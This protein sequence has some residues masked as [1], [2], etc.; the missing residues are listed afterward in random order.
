MPKQSAGILLYRQ[1]VKG[2]EM[3][4]VH[5]G[6]PFWAKKD[7]GVWSIPK[8]EFGQQEQPETAARRE[9]REEVGQNPPGGELIG[10]GSSKSK[11]GKTIYIWATLGN[12]D[13]KAIKSN[14]FTMQWPLHSGIEQAFPEVDRAGWFGFEKALQKIGEPQAI[15]IER[16]AEHL[17]IS[18]AK[19]EQ[20]TLF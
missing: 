3:L 12:L 19:I 11:S 4:L 8:G 16:L 14:T 15:F 6:G 20:A 5:P 9:F 17:N 10:L 13:E 2:V 1:N 18:L 7:K